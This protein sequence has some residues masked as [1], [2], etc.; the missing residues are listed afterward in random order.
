MHGAS[1]LATV[2]ALVYFVTVPIGGSFGSGSRHTNII[3][4]NYK[5]R[6]V[7]RV[8]RQCGKCSRLTVMVDEGVRSDDK[9]RF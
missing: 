3:W 2:S 4:E 5:N 7:Q 1:V 9:M 8:G 6:W